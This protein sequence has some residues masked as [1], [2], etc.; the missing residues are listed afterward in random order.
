M[1]ERQ[2]L[3]AL[4]GCVD[5]VDFPEE[6]KLALLA[7]PGLEMAGLRAL[8]NSV[9]A[10][11]GVIGVLRSSSCLITSSIPG[12]G[13]LGSSD[14]RVIDDGVFRAGR[15]GFGDRGVLM[16]GTVGVGVGEDDDVGVAD[17]EVELSTA[18]DG[19]G[20]DASDEGGEGMM[21]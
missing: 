18:D 2:L 10:C 12:A 19:G 8:R 1:H 9:Y 20:D 6:E 5:G 14:G 3:P 13:L 7:V 11:G 21:I 15:A 4:D 16:I 17:D